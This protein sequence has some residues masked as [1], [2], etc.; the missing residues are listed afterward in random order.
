MVAHSNGVSNSAYGFIQFYLSVGDTGS[1]KFATGSSC[2]LDFA[3]K[4][5]MV[6]ISDVGVTP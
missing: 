2:D 5:R 6:S 1:T 4:D 3:D